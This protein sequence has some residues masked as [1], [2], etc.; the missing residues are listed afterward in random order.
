MQVLPLTTSFE[1]SVILSLEI[2]VP[3]ASPPAELGNVKLTAL[4]K[5]KLVTVKNTT[6]FE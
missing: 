3:C 6:F 4:H 2:A 5:I 1:K